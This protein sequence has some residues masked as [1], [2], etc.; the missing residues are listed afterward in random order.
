MADNGVDAVV[1]GLR[2]FG[3]QAGEAVRP[4]QTLL[5]EYLRD[6]S[7]LTFSALVAR[8]GRIVMGVS[9]S[10]LGDGPD[11]EDV[12]QATFL[13]L[14]RSTTSIRNRDSV[15]SWLHGVAFRLACKVRDRSRRR[16][17]VE[18]RNVRGEAMEM[19]DVTWG[20][21]R[22][23][24]HEEVARLPEKYRLPLLL[25]YWSGLTQDEAAARL[26][27]TR[28]V[29]R[30]RLER[31]R[32]LLRSRLARR[33]FAPGFLL[34]ASLLTPAT[35]T[36]TVARETCRA[37]TTVG[38][39]ASAVARPQV[40]ALLNEVLQTMPHLPKPTSVLALAAVLLA[41]G[42]AAVGLPALAQTSPALPSSGGQGL[43]ADGRKTDTPAS[44]DVAR[45]EAV[46]LLEGLTPHARAE[47]LTRIARELTKAGDKASARAL[48]RLAAEAALAVKD[49]GIRGWVL[50]AVAREQLEADDPKGAAGAMAQEKN[51]ARK[52]FGLVN[53]SAYRNRVGNQRGARVALRE[54]E[55]LVKPPKGVQPDYEQSLLYQALERVTEAKLQAGDEDGAYKSAALATTASGKPWREWELWRLIAVARAR[56][57]D[58]SGAVEVVKKIEADYARKDRSGEIK[59][60]LGPDESMDLWLI[61]VPTLRDVAVARAEAGGAKA[62]PEAVEV[63]TLI[64][65][66]DDM[67]SAPHCRRDALRLIARRQAGAGD[68]AGARK[69][70]EGL[71]SGE[72]AQVLQ[73][74][75]D[76]QL[77]KGDTKAAAATLTEALDLVRPDPKD[78]S[79][80]EALILLAET[81]AKTGDVDGARKTADSL[82]GCQPI[83][84]NSFDHYDLPFQPITHRY[85]AL[86]LVARTQLR[87]GDVK[88]AIATAQLLVD[89]EE[90][91]AHAEL[92][93]AYC[94]R[95]VARFKVR[96]GEKGAD[97]WAKER[98]AG[99]ERDWALEGVALGLIEQSVLPGD[100]K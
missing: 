38:A 9:R 88:G 83:Y 84:L 39:G 14:A 48:L 87:K 54:A 5:E 37:A 80:S 85:T 25:C 100:T 17:D 31:G 44:Q 57:G 62:I 63:A 91:G 65:S 49:E 77:R 32:N 23:A 36:A 11:A 92:L 56:K 29:V 19:D 22:E 7:E 6:R 68:F 97:A 60:A 21:L 27:W 55:E 74:V 12:F 90:A 4:D 46:K 94:A 15:S 41:A 79:M 72:Q 89:D 76:A 35:V 99:R 33:G 78:V 81:Q 52:S 45:A 42:V 66:E 95:E 16:A 24:L 43:P 73:A 20:E 93:R 34:C 64:S 96:S 28:P 58:T 67:T 3:A 53:T 71:T 59:A 50:L 8:Y 18:R 86:A 61:T 26:G 82:K 51:P 69:T 47:A 13:A 98:P 10:V 30:D 1:R 75:A 70:S 40:I 2:R